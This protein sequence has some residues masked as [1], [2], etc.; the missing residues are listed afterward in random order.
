[1]ILLALEITVLAVLVGVATSS[2]GYGLVTLFGGSLLLGAV[3]IALPRVAALLGAALGLAW[4]AVGFAFGYL[5]DG[6]L[7]LALGL[8]LTGLI[9]GLGGNS[10]LFS[11]LSKRNGAQSEKRELSRSDERPMEP[12]RAANPERPTEP[13][14]VWDAREVLGVGPRASRS[15]VER[16]F[17]TRMKQY[18]PAQL[19]HL[20]PELRQLAEHKAHE[21]RA[22]RDALTR[23]GR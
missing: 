5:D 3:T 15:E 1:M 20:G 14:K 8:R 12:L 4:G 23:F 13:T 22:A 19:S 16:A 11:G 10:F 17:R 2:P 6:N 18:D 9:L 21:I 7:P